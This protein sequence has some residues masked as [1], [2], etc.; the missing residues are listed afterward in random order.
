[1]PGVLHLVHFLRSGEL[2]SV[3]GEYLSKFS[4][5]T[6]SLNN[7]LI[8]DYEFVYSWAMWQIFVLD[9]FYYDKKFS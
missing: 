8:N 2:F 5:E 9:S 1:M 3:E 6:Y 4:F 7:L